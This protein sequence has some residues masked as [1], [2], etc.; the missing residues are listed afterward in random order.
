MFSINDKHIIV[1]YH[2]VEDPNP[3]FS[4]ITPCSVPEFDRQVQ[5]LS[6]N[7]RIVSVPEVYEAAQAGKADRL[8]AITF[9]DGLKD[10][11]QNALPILEKYGAS[12]TFFIITSTFEGRLPPAHKVHILLSKLPIEQSIDTFH[13]FL[14]EFYPDLSAQ[15]LI[16]KDR[17]LTQKRLHESPANANFKE[18]MITLP[19]DIKGQFLRY[20]FKQFKIKEEKISRNLFMSQEEVKDLRARGMVVG[21]HSHS[22]YSFDVI[23]EET[24]SNEVKL[25]SELLSGMLGSA[26]TIF[27]YPHGRQGKDSGSVL[28]PLGMKYAVNIVRKAVEK[29]DE[30]F[31]IPRYDTAD[32]SI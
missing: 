2:Y 27:S 9:D 24:A 25:T 21:N 6:K 3:K 17:R 14:K 13:G 12:G 11:Y 29:G 26:P 22:H 5:F 8:C 16:P 15:Y 30:R 10:Q 18:T 32:I 28:E 23:S 19:E 31:S 7:Y 1:N 4:G 20:C